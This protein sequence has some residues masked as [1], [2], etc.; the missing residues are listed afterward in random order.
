M[1]MTRRPFLILVL[2]VALIHASLSA[3]THKRT[4][5]LLDDLQIRNT[6]SLFFRALEEKGHDLRFFEATHPDLQLSKYGDYLYDNVVI[7]APHVEGTCTSA[8][9]CGAPHSHSFSFPATFYSFEEFLR[10]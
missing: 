8:Q 2:S 3:T 6:H 5:V 4:L 10:D 7:F 9:L 1:M